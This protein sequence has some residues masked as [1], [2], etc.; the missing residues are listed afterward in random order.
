M[1]VFDPFSEF[2]KGLVFDMLVECYDALL[3]ELPAEKV[4]ELH[5]DWLSYD[6]A[7]FDEPDTVGECG[8]AT[9]LNDE[10]I[11]FG[12]WNPTGWPEVGVI[13][14]NCILP[15]FQGHGYGRRQI[16]EILRRFTVWEFQKARVTTDELPF[17]AP[18]RRI[19]ERCGFSEVGR[20]RGVLVDGFDIIDYER[21]L[22]TDGP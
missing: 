21:I 7:V 4:E 8:F 20:R 16:E 1:I 11:G 10:V 2:R 14:H 17:F 18:A 19:Y 22:A 3:E 5:A 13:G 12:S 15:K 6:A 9:R